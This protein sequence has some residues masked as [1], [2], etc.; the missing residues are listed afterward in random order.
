MPFFMKFTKKDY[1]KQ[2]VLEIVSRRIL[3]VILKY[4]YIYINTIVCVDLR[5]LF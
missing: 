1:N 4:N 3:L 2:K 5:I